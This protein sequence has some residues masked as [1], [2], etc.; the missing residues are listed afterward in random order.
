M[1]SR[2][3]CAPEWPFLFDGRVTL[4]RTYTPPS[5]SPS[6]CCCTFGTQWPAGRASLPEAALTRLLLSS[7]QKLQREKEPKNLNDTVRELFRV[8][9]GNVDPLL[10]KKAVGCRRCAVVG[11]SGNLRGSWYGPHIDSHDFVLRWVPRA[12]S[13]PPPPC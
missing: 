1:F 11:N 4:Q 3:G 7:A 12:A 9:P 5:L 10:E 2:P 13:P 8:V 6:L